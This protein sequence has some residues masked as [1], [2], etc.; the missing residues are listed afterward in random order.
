MDKIAR[1]EVSQE[2]MILVEEIPEFI[3]KVDFGSLHEKSLSEKID[4]YKEALAANMISMHQAVYSVFKDIYSEDEIK[5]MV[6]DIKL[7]KGLILTPI[8]AEFANINTIE[9]KV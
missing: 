1:N 6:I 5:Q 7:E 4:V 3:V 9:E 2:G 8:E